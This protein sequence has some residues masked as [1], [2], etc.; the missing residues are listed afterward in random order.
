MPLKLNICPSDP[1]W[2]RL[3]DWPD[4]EVSRHGGVRRVTPCRNGKNKSRA[5]PYPLK[6]QVYGRSDRQYL[7][8]TLTSP[9]GKQKAI[10]VHRLVALAF[11]PPALDGQTQVAH[12]DGN[13]LNNFVENLAWVSPWE[14]EYHKQLHAF[15]DVVTREGIAQRDTPQK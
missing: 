9:E 4:Y 13:S 7:N 6:Q 10:G 15:G 1:C 2:T 5:L 14:N 11:L 3:D 12:L 8:V